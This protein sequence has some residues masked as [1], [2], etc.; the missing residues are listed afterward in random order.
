MSEGSRH[1][2]IDYNSLKCDL[3]WTWMWPALAEICADRM[4]HI[5][6]IFFFRA[7]T[8]NH[9]LFSDYS[10]TVQ[11]IDDN[12]MHCTPSVCSSVYSSLITRKRKEIIL[13]SLNLVSRSQYLT[14]P[15]NEMC[16]T[17]LRGSWPY[18]F[19]T[20]WKCC[21]THFHMQRTSELKFNKA[22]TWQLH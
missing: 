20:R 1:N 2:E 21:S 8:S 4:L 11:M 10:T 18:S 19:Q 12:I 15:G 7:L 16:C 3:E 22:Y 6:H 13:R 5:K 9:R 14:N 17:L